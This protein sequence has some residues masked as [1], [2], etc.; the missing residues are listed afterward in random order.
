MALYRIAQEALN[1]AVKHSS[2]S[3]ITITLAYLDERDARMGVEGGTI[4]LAVKDNGVGFINNRELP[5][6]LSVLG[7]LGEGT[8]FTIRLPRET[9]RRSKW[10]RN[11]GHSASVGTR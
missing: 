8:R 3:T 11:S 9:L 10:P 7:R 4:A 6:L 1:N 5:D 2:S